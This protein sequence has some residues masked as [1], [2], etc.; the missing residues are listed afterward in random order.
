MTNLEK[1]ILKHSDYEPTIAKNQNK[2]FYTNRKIET[3]N[4]N[5]QNKLP[6]L[7]HLNKP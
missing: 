3:K 7:L 4:K 6:D 5:I 1:K 2:I